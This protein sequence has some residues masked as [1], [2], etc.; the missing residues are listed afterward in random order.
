MKLAVTSQGTK[1]DSPVDPRFG[2]AKYFVVVDTDTMAISAHDNAQNLNAPQGAGIQ[3]GQAVSRLGVEAILTGHVGP[4]AFATLAAAH[5]TV[6]TGVSG[7]VKDAVEQFKQGQLEVA[8]QA[9]V[10]GH[11]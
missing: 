4:K 2:R 7:T 6:Y 11:W 5:V 8:A 1:L 10:Q 3:A 9:D